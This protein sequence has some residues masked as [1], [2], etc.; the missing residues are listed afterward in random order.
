MLRCFTALMKWKLAWLLS[1]IVGWL[2]LL[3]PISEAMDANRLT[4]LD[5]TDPYYVGAQFPKLTSPQWVGEPGVDAVVILAIDDMK[6]PDAYATF[7]GPI[8][9]RLKQIDGRA[10][11]SIMCNR[12]DP[13]EPQYQAWLKEGL[14]LEVHTLSHPCPILDGKNFQSAVNEFQ[15]GIDLIDQVP[16]NHACAFRT[17][18]CDS[19]N[20]PSPRL[21]AELF[22][23]PN[24][25]GR[26]LTIDSSV[27]NILSTTD[28]V[29]PR[30]LVLDADGRDK[31]R[32]IC[33]LSLVRDHGREL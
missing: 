15:G 1:C 3:P 10:P 21:F 13:Q 28:P 8:L 33:S 27:M 4:Y 12:I 29:L 32:K 24:S 14:S 11:V 17:P 2:C 7:L 22:N 18:C 16:G 6:S 9:E 26:F 20:S 23:Q 30:D 19:M 31:F 25:S 5:Q